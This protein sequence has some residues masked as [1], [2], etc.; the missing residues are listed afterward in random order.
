MHACICSIMV[1]GA[2]RALGSAQ[3]ARSPGLRGQET[4][5]PKLGEG[6]CHREGRKGRKGDEHGP[7]ACCH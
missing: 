6:L 3:A 7:M 5:P 2:G 4:P 1:E